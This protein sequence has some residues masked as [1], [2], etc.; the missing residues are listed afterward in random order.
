M[1]TIPSSIK[2]LEKDSKRIIFEVEPLYP[3]YGVTLGNALRRVLL[4]SIE[5]AA[6]VWV[7]IKGA[8]HEFMTLPG[9][10]E[11]VLEITLNLKRVRLKCFSDEPQKLELKVSGEREVKAGDI[12]T[13][14]D[15]EIVNK[16]LHIATLT[17]PD[18]KLEMEMEVQKG[19][20]YKKAEELKEGKESQVGQIYIDAIFSPIK[21][22]AFSV[23]DI[24]FE[25]RTDY[26]KL[27]ME[28]ETDETID[29]EIAVGKALNILLSQFGRLK[30]VFKAE[31][32]EEKKEEKK[33][34]EEKEESKKEELSISLSDLN[35]STRTLNALE[36]A[37]IKS[38]R[39]LL[40]RK[41]ESLREIEGLGEK[42]IEEIKKALKKRN[43][44]LK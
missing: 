41:E 35:L 15:V 14:S 27:R 32:K 22:V 31:E 44:S 10:K 21:R 39:G 12:K 6:I 38:L 40:R 33:E 16:D 19:L 20:G 30:E 36:K 37:G 11:D 2:I 24:R 25:K 23:E 3:G 34:K 43:L 26:N 29:P 13:P 18:A 9:I 8:P 4:S 7:K 1:I 42:G 17:S 28:V 5:G